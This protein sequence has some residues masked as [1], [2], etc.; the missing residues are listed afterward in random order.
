MQHVKM[1][2]KS[3]LKPKAAQPVEPEVEEVETDIEE[4]EPVEEEVEEVED[5]EDEEGI[6]HPDIVAGDPEDNLDLE[7]LTA[8]LQA[9][10]GGAADSNADVWLKKIA[11]ELRALNRNIVAIGRR[12]LSQ[13]RPAARP[14]VDRTAPRQVRTTK[15]VK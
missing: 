10:G 3:S 4:E 11:Y 13:H 7:Q 1:A 15:P 6:E 5:V 12:M 8:M 14:Q 2:K 9:F